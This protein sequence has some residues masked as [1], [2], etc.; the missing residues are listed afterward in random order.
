M[1]SKKNRPPALPMFKLVYTYS[2][3]EVYYVEADNEGVAREM[4]EL[5]QMPE[6]SQVDMTDWNLDVEREDN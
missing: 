4:F 3:R 6:P 1:V 5:A 2:K